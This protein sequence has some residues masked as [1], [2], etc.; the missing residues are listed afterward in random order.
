MRRPIDVLA[1]Y[2]HLA[3]AAKLR[4]QPLVRDRV[5]LLAG[6]IAAQIDLEP[7]AAACRQQILVNN[8]RHLVNRWPT[9]GAALGYEDFQSLV[10]Q[11][12]T[13]YGPERVEQLVHQLGVTDAE[14]RAD[15]ASDGEYAAALMDLDWDDLQ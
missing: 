5:L 15:Y 14:E 13:R 12:S 10:G 7:I 11:L 9:I 3:R 4:G 6:V 8:P 1:S 2:L